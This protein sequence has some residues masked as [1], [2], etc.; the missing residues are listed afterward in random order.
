VQDIAQHLP[1][2]LVALLL[3][4]AISLLIGFER[5]EYREDRPGSFFGGVRTYPLIGLSGFLLALSFPKSAVP[6]AT[7]LL[8]LGALLALSHFTALKTPHMGI[9]SEIS[10]LLTYGLG[11]AAAAGFHWISVA[12]GIIAVL[13]LHEKERLEGLVDRVPRRELG[14][15]LRFL[16]MTGVILPVVPNHEF[17]TFSINPFKI[18]LVVVA[19]SAV[20]Y[21]S[22]LLQLR[23]GGRGLIPAAILGGAYSSTATTVVLARQS[24]ISKRRPVRYAGAILTATGVM[25]VR[26]WILVMLF[27]QHLGERLTAIFWTAGLSAIVVGVFLDRYRRR[28]YPTTE[29]AD[30]ERG[31]A[32]NPLE[33]TAAFT[34]AGIFLVV[35]VITRL[36]AER[37]GGTGVLALA[38]IMGATD[39]DPFILGLTQSAGQGITIATAA[40]A[41][42][43]A[44]AANN[45]MKGVYALIFGDLR[46]G[47]LALALLTLWGAATIVV[48]FAM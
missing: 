11:G 4:L 44:A 6:F 23:F 36:V 41:V 39:V 21:L 37:F 14:T 28:D 13:L 40:A 27:A 3:T 5:E 18:W 1:P 17:T 33:L 16:L 30:E 8:A 25:Y 7:G 22:Y 12:V 46:A 43:I 19:V 26:L 15:L 47:R 48:F 38:A 20:S 34:F 35:L 31:R 32:G 29:S 45:L 2:N 42:V 9:T 10:A 24:K